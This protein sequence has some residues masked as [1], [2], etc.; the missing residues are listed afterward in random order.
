VDTPLLESWF[1]LPHH[2]GKEGL[3][4]MKTTGKA[5]DKHRAKR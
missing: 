2:I 1:G 4:A 5:F 3:E